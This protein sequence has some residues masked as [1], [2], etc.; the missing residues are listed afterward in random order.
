M[1]RCSEKVTVQLRTKCPPKLVLPSTLQSSVLKAED[2][3]G[4]QFNGDLKGSPGPIPFA[5]LANVGN[6][7][8]TQARRKVDAVTTSPS[9]LEIPMPP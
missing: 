4:S 1:P 9:A 5:L 2:Q 3:W 7:R 6:A 8:S